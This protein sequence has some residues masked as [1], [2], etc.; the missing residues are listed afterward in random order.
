MTMTEETLEASMKVADGKPKSGKGLQ[1]QTFLV[2]DEVYLRTFRVGDHKNATSWRNSV[3]PKSAALVKQWI[4]E[5]LPKEGKAQRQHLAIVRKEDDTIVG[6]VLIKYDDLACHVVPYVDPLYG[7]AGARWKAEAIRLLVEWLVDENHRPVVH[8][9]LAANEATVIEAV[10]AIGMRECARFR[11]CYLIDGKR[12]DK[13]QLEYLNKGWVET[14][15]DP[16]EMGLE[17]TG[18][19][20]PRPVPPRVTVEGDPPKNAMMIGKRVYLR[21]EEKAETKLIA[22][23]SRQETETF[24]DIGRHL[25]SSVV[26]AS[27]IDGQYEKDKPGWIWFA[28]CLRETDKVIGAVGLLRVDYV[29]LTAET[30]SIF[31]Q[32]EYRGSG[33]GSEAKQLL[34]EY[35]FDVLG[36][37][38]LESWVLFP[39]TRSAAALRK[40]G[41][42]EAGRAHWIYPHNGRFD[43]FVV[44]DLL[45]KEWRAMPR[46]EWD[47]KA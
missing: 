25:M 17:R 23:W 27:W 8:V 26:H 31:H 34:L 40:Q 22:K 7:N 11:E 2:G 15:G 19:G 35:A 32:K 4:K 42:R 3:F 5:E 18:T 6:S 29:N 16:N 38:M 13:I 41:Y 20:Q 14:L 21:P 24:F 43:N 44:F 12:V 9:T 10:Q 30:G 46:A 33:Y 36:L 39:N 28:V 1:G 37:H 45:A 47:A